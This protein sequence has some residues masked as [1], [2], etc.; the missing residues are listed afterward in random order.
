MTNQTE[1]VYHTPVMLPE[2]LDALQIEPEGCYVDVTFGGGGHSRAIVERLCGEGRLFAFDQDADAMCN[3]Q[4]DEH[5]VF[6]AGNFRYLYR[7]M[8]YYG[9]LGQVDGI[10]ADLGVSG[11]HFDDASRGFSFRSEEPL[12]DMRMNT[13]GGKSAADLIND[14]EEQA[15]A[16]VFYHYGEL[17]Q[18]RRLAA[19]IV[20]A[21]ATQPLLTV[22]DLIRTVRPELNPRDEKK[23]LSC[24][25]QALR[26]EVNDELSALEEMLAATVDVLRPGGLLVVM[27]YHSLE[28]RIVKNFLKTTV[29]TG[30]DA[31]IYGSGPA[32]WE[33]LTRKPIVPGSEEIG[34]NP[35]ARSAKLRIAR[36]NNLF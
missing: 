7:Y 1:P 21:R 23:Q 13:R 33:V 9:R 36:L 29:S 16:N 20:Q 17:R 6:T 24:L 31:R 34:R 25:F 11:H 22:G 27:T 3:V 5:F 19:R 2:C 12:M 32:L 28:D 8:D 18:S 35:R 15:L 4:P 26:I 30:A 10:L 14:Y